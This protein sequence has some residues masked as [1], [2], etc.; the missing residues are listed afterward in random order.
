MS[1]EP[2]CLYDVSD[3]VATITLN[4]PHRLN[5]F[6]AQSYQQ[7]TEAFHKADADPEVRCIILTGAGRGFCSG[8]DVE[9]LMGGDG[10]E[11]LS[12]SDAPRFEIPGV[13]MGRT[14]RPIIAAVNGAAVGYG[15]EIALLADI[16]I[17]AES[18]KFSQMFVK[19]GLVA[20]AA[21]FTTLN[22]LLGPAGAAELLLTGDL[23]DAQRA[24]EMG[25]VSAVFPTES[26]LD[27][28]RALA[29]RIAS[30]PPLAV[31]RA[32]QALQL[33][34]SSSEEL[35]AQARDALAELVRT[36]DHKESVAAFLEKREP[37]YRGV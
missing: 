17:A 6:N 23:I 7:T 20:G 10:L 18:A 4:R 19:R 27:E 37:R 36:E 2:L 30:N 28:A 35:K 33:A 32:K 16:R 8:D 5:A 13:V 26:L 3:H 11:G 12:A 21:S 31:R 15:F 24:L 29:A 1:N 25:V 14:D 9:E 34:R 22:Q